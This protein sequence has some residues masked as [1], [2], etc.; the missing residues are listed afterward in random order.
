MNEKRNMASLPAASSL[1]RLRHTGK[2]AG[3]AADHYQENRA[4]SKKSGNS[5]GGQ[6][7]TG[8][9]RNTGAAPQ[10]EEQPAPKPAAPEGKKSKYPVFEYPYN[11]ETDR[12]NFDYNNIDI[13]VGDKRYMTQIND[14]FMNFR[15]YKDKTVLIE[16]Y[17]ISINGHYFVGRN[18]PTCPYCTGG[19]VDFEFTSD[20]DFTGYEDG[21][22]WIKVY[23]ILR[24]ATVHL[25]DHLTAPFYHL[26]AVKVEKMDQ[27][28]IGTIT[29]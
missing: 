6:G 27:P 16:G 12:Q 13:V 5:S 1:R 7:N 19:Y 14:W 15:D 28:G 20:G 21:V 25:N 2:S 4:G 3:S 17:F 23:G 9:G 10:K 24:E 22:T 11:L 8:A 29:D 26:E 18:G